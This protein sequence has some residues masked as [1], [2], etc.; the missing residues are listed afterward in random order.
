MSRQ[1]KLVLILGSLAILGIGVL[2]FLV[3]R[4]DPEALEQDL[5]GQIA[6]SSGLQV[7]RQSGVKL[8]FLPPGATLT[9]L[10]LSD[11][12]REILTV[13]RVQVGIA[14]LPLLWQKVRLSSL[15][16][17]EPKLA[18]RRAGSGAVL[19]GTSGKAPEFLPGRISVRNG[20]L[21]ALDAAGTTLLELTGLDFDLDAL[22]RDETGRVSLSGELESGRLSSDRVEVT[23]LRGSLAGDGHSYRI[24]PLR[25]RLFGSAARGEFTVDLGGK[26]PA[27]KLELTAGDLSLAELSRSLAG[28]PLFEGSV[29]LRADLSGKGAA[30]IADTLSGTLKV[31]GTQLVQHGFD[32]DHFVRKYRDS[33]DLDLVDIGVYAFAGPMGALVSKGVD[34]MGLVWPSG[35]KDRQ[36]IEELVF[37]WSLQNGVARA[38]DVAMRT[39]EN[40]LALKGTINL[41]QGSYDGMT[42]GLLNAQGCAELTEKISGP[43]DHPKVEK[44]SILET[45]AGSLV[46]IL[47]QGV[48]IINPNNCRP[49]YQGTVVHPGKE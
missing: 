41:S 43:L 14:L 15:V 24:A 28:G 20:T 2:A 45:L 42:L 12:T 46:G 30:K 37:N 22:R 1:R 19:P 47:K 6:A 48:V 9:G 38:E 23:E 16:L 26:Q 31:S 39:R 13:K 44:A 7:E 17:D 36:H 29:N 3:F 34:V 21:R 18:I 8:H 27:W 33:R 32:I 40:R 49:F 5:K 11:G 35:G 4:I 10:T 25:G